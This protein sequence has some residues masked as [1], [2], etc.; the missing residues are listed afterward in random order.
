MKRATRELIAYVT[1]PER[2]HFGALGVSP[3]ELSGVRDATVAEVLGNCR[4]GRAAHLH[5]DRGA[6]EPPGVQKLLHDAMSR[7]NVAHDA[8]SKPT[9]RRRYELLLR[10][11]HASCDFCAGR[12]Q[13]TARRTLKGAVTSACETCKGEGYVPRT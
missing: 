7:V 11:T 10:K 5:P 9:E 4:R 13:I 12:G 8:L 3:S 6:N 2:T 1:A